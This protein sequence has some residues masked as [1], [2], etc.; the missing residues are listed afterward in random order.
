MYQRL[1]S[2]EFNGGYKRHCGGRDFRRILRI[3]VELSDALYPELWRSQLCHI[4]LRPE[5]LRSVHSFPTERL[6]KS[7]SPELDVKRNYWNE[8][9]TPTHIFELMA[10]IHRWEKDFIE[11]FLLMEFNCFNSLLYYCCVFCLTLKTCSSILT[12]QKIRFLI[13]IVLFSSFA[14]YYSSY[15]S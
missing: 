8:V 3:R 10:V 5:Q 6:A 13:S 1:H 4:P 12:V 11:T 9:L 2:F 7:G 15:S 14:R